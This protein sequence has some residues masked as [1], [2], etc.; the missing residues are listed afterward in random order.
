METTIFPYLFGRSG[1]AEISLLQL[2]EDKACKKY[3]NQLITN[4][5]E[6]HLDKENLISLLFEKIDSRKDNTEK[7]DEKNDPQ[8]KPK[9]QY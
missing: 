7:V 4:K 5:K 6:I 8:N 1:G 2:L 9:T 3:N